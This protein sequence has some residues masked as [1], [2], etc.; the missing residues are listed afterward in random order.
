[1]S[2]GVPIMRV[3]N[4]LLRR[5]VAR[6]KRW[7]NSTVSLRRSWIAASRSVP[8]NA[9]VS[10]NQAS[11]WVVGYPSITGLGKI[12]PW[13]GH[14]IS[15]LGSAYFSSYPYLS[16]SRGDHPAETAYSALFPAKLLKRS[17]PSSLGRGPS[18]P[19]HLS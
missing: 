13:C 9:F 8:R 15:P 4:T 1:M 10:A 19:Q 6:L 3:V 11:S 18:V 14:Q 16:S 12:C 7:L 17:K 2:T 5:I